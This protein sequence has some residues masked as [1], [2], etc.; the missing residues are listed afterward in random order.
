MKKVALVAIIACL[1]GPGD[2]ASGQDA[3]TVRLQYAAA[4]DLVETLNPL[5][6]EKVRLVPDA[7]TNTILVRA[8]ANKI[9]S[10]L[11]RIAALDASS[12]VKQYLI[13]V[14]VCRGD[15]LGTKNTIEVLS[16]PA[17]MVLEGQPAKVMIGQT[18]VGFDSVTEDFVGVA[19]HC[20]PISEK[21]GTIRLEIGCQ[22]AELVEQT[23]DHREIRVLSG[24]QNREVGR[25]E[26]FKMRLKG[27]SATD[28]TWLE[29]TVKE[30]RAA[31]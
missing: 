20:R 18:L 1:A 26:T 29:G 17:M 24:R 19:I 5:V 10:V 15:P 7:I 21:D 12:K 8:P 3:K 11:R 13:E 28:Q 30:I 4:A 14:K 27:A 9:E 22:V 31:Q 25:G 16:R 6:G 2:R 23:N